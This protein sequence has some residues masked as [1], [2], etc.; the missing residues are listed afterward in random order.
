MFWICA[1]I[2]SIWIFYFFSSNLLMPPTTTTMLV[3]LVIISNVGIFVNSWRF[4]IPI[5]FCYSAQ[6]SLQ[7]K[8]I[9]HTL[10]KRSVMAHY[11]NPN[12][13]R[14]LSMCVCALASIN[15]LKLHCCLFVFDDSLPGAWYYASY[16]ASLLT[17]FP[18]N[19]QKK[20]K[21]KRKNLK[22][23]FLPL[24]KRKRWWWRR[25]E[26]ISLKVSTNI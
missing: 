3:L 17:V 2:C 8:W 16:H 20:N 21:R 22:N 5:T 18:T 13:H 4:R 24:R 19:K 14:H 7:R 9:I 1:F 25:R 23:S 11:W 15:D 12:C 26:I 10:Y 6:C